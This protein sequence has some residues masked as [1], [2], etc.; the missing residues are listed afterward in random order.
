MAAYGIAQL[1][2]A[3]GIRQRHSIAPRFGRLVR[4]EDLI[5]HPGPEE[6]PKEAVV[7]GDADEHDKD[8]DVDYGLKV[9][10]VVHGAHAGNEA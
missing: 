2:Q 5:E 10:A 6:D 1:I 8:E 7:L 3:K 9:L 4:V